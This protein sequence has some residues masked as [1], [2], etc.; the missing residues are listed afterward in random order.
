MRCATCIN[1]INKPKPNQKYCIVCNSIRLRANKKKKK[2]KAEKTIE[3]TCTTCEKKFLSSYKIEKFCSQDCK[4][5]QSTRSINDTWENDGK[6]KRTKAQQN[7][8]RIA[9]N[10]FPV[11]LPK[12]TIP[13]H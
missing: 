7:K 10:N 11:H 6:K 1:I 8:L 13:R 12:E 4:D 5:F 9:F 2:A 3:R